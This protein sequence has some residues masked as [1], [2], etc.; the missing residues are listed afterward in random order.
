MNDKLVAP[1]VKDELIW[2]VKKM[3]WN[4]ALSPIGIV[5]QFFTMFWEV[6]R[7]DYFDM[8]QTWK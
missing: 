3:A 2:V 7:D 1:I 5:V 6:I 8:I 4:K